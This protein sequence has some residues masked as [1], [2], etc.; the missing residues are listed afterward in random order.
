MLGGRALGVVARDRRGRS[1][2]GDDEDAVAVERR[3]AARRVWVVGVA[4][5]CADLVAALRPAPTIRRSMS[6]NRPESGRFDQVVSAVTWKSTIRPSPRL[7]AV[8]IGV[9]SASAA[10]VLRVQVAVGLGEDLAADAD[11]GRHRRGRRTGSR[12]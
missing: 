7:S 3:A 11:L 2:G 12:A 8:T 4:R 1:A 10:Q 6:T 5:L 9:P